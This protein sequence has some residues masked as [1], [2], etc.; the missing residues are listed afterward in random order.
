MIGRMMG[1]RRIC[2]CGS[3]NVYPC[4]AGQVCPTCFGEWFTQWQQRVTE[5]A[6]EWGKAHPTQ[7]GYPR[8]YCFEQW[9]LDEDNWRYLH[10]A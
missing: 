7:P 4:L 5:Q 6:R 1:V 9:V 3:L 8:G 10:P 2:D